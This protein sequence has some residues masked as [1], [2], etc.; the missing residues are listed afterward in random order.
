MEIRVGEQEYTLDPVE[1]SVDESNITPDLCKIGATMLNYGAVEARLRTEV[2]S[3]EA[4]LEKLKAD[5]DTQIRADAITSGEKLTEPKIVHR[6]N[7]DPAYQELLLSLRLSKESFN[8]MRWAMIALQKKTDILISLAYRE[9]Q[10][11]KADSF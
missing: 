1:F 2:A 4:Y 11:I 9:R 6:I 3:K 7:A 8:I 10:L 5:L